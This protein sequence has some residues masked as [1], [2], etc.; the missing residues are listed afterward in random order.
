MTR[1]EAREVAVHYT[2]TLTFSTL[3]AEELLAREFTRDSFLRWE[4][5]SDLYAKFPGE[6]QRNY[7]VSLVTG[8]FSHSAE[9]DGYIAGYSTGRRFERIDRLAAA[10]L[11]VAMYEILY[12]PET[13][14]KVCVS[15]ALEIAKKYLND[16]LVHYINGIL[17]SF[18]RAEFPEIGQSD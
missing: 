10:I 5:E 6:K 3:T 1:R 11:R 8:V 2:Y 18:L 4:K 15:E 12:T 9:L 7:I 14:K 16:D 13:P 17:G